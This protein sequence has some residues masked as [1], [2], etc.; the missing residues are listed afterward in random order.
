[1]LY[2]YPNDRNM[3][4]KVMVDNAIKNPYTSYPF[5]MDSDSDDLDLDLDDE[6]TEPK[7][8][9]ADDS[10]SYDPPLVSGAPRPAVPAGIDLP[11]PNPNIPAPAAVALPGSP[12]GSSS[13]TVVPVEPISNRLRQ[14]TGLA[15]YNEKTLEAIAHGEDHIKGEEDSPSPSPRPAIDSPSDRV[16]TSSRVAF[17]DAQTSSGSCS[18]HPD[19]G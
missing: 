10:G 4:Q 5:P 11:L 13:D 16:I 14:R 19:A 7:P 3:R 1:M 17:C 12:D 15:V 2:S 18:T 9:P 8:E 6:A